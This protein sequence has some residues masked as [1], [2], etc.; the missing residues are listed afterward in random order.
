MSACADQEFPDWM[1]G[2]CNKHVIETINAKIHAV[3]EMR[4]RTAAAEESYNNACFLANNIYATYT[5]NHHRMC[6][7]SGVAEV[8]AVDHKLAELR[9]LVM[10]ISALKHAVAAAIRGSR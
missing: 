4:T 8:I 9:T 1:I 7:A 3:S 2:C 10:E 6:L 5:A